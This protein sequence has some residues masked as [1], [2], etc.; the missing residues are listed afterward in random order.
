[1][2]P[3]AAQAR[4]RELEEHGQEWTGE[5]FMAWLLGFDDKE[6]TGAVLIEESERAFELADEHY[7]RL[8]V[9][10]RGLIVMQ[11]KMM[12]QVGFVQ[13]ATFA[14]AALGRLPF[15]AGINTLAAD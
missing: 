14:C 12:V 6:T 4:M 10:R 9:G 13:G 8:V 2:T 1:M 5:D 15:P 11:P 3:H 7:S